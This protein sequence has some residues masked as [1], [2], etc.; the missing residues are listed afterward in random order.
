MGM[1]ET[2]DSANNYAARGGQRLMSGQPDAAIEDFNAALALDPK[3]ASNIAD[4]GIAYLEKGEIERAQSDPDKAMAIDPKNAVAFV[5]RGMLAAK[6]GDD[7]TAISAF[8]TVLASAPDDAVAL[9][10]RAESYYRTRQLDKALVDVTKAIKVAP[11]GTRGYFLRAMILH[12]QNH[13]EEAIRQAQLAIQA[14]PKSAD[15]Y[16]IAGE[17]YAFLQDNK[18]AM[19]AFSHSININPS[20]AAY[21]RRAQMRPSTDLQGQLEDLRAAVSLNPDSARDLDMLSEIEAEDG[22]YV[23]SISHLSSVIKLRG[24]TVVLLARRGADYAK[25]KQMALADKD[26]AAAEAKAQDPRSLNSLCWTL[27]THGVSMDKAMNACDAAIATGRGDE[28][29]HF[30]DSKGFLLLKLGRC[31]DAMASYEKALKLQPLM[32]TSLYGRGIC[33]LREGQK[34]EAQEDMK[35]GMDFS[36]RAVADDFVRYGVKP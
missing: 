2:I 34:K 22:D 15:A 33:E 16:G 23:D 4:R 18:Q 10:M 3:D 28:L 31:K 26:F 19:L 24:E 25:T 36:N 5:G 27:A 9:G 32:A 30:F 8:T 6:R 13:P 21:V 17:I 20:E 12:G 14:N 29:A 11:Q 1:P 7:E 35:D